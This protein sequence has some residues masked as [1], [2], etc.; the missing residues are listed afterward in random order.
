MYRHTCDLSNVTAYLYMHFD[1]GFADECG[2]KEG[3]EGD[4][5]VPTGNASQVKQGV[6]DLGH[7]RSH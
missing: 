1:D 5:E 3:P 6:G 7:T 2:T 4:E